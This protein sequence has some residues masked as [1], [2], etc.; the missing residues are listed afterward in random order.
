MGKILTDLTNTGSNRSSLQ[1]DD[2]LKYVPGLKPVNADGGLANKSVYP[3]NNSGA[4]GPLKFDNYVLSGNIRPLELD[5]NHLEKMGFDL[6]TKFLEYSASIPHV[7]NLHY[8]NN[9]TSV[10]LNVN[11]FKL[12]NLGKTFDFYPAFITD[13]LGENPDAGGGIGAINLDSELRASDKKPYTNYQKNFTL[14]PVLFKQSDYNGFQGH[15]DLIFWFTVTNKLKEILSDVN[16]SLPIVYVNRYESDY[17]KMHPMAVTIPPYDPGT[18]VNFLGHDLDA[19][20][21][22]QA[23]INGQQ[24][25]LHRNTNSNKI[26]P[27][28]MLGTKYLDLTKDQLRKLGFKFNGLKV[29]YDCEIPNFNKDSGMQIT[30]NGTEA[31]HERTYFAGNGTFYFSCQPG[32]MNIDINASATHKNTSF[33]KQDFYPVFISNL[34]GIQRVK[35]KFGNFEASDKWTDAYFLSAIRK[36]VP[37][38]VKQDYPGSE[39]LVFW[40]NVTPSFLALLPD[41]ISKDM[42]KEYEKL[43]NTESKTPDT[44][45]TTCKYFDVCQVPLE[46]EYGVK[47]YP[48]P[49]KDKINLEFWPPKNDGTVYTTVELTDLNGR[50]IQKNES[51][52]YGRTAEM[53][54]EGVKPGIYL[55]VYKLNTGEVITNKVMITR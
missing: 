17:R 12:M 46:Q 3:Q 43:V 24:F 39:D 27:S 50:V 42:G 28:D 6:K 21:T 54:L 30:N 23:T 18:K 48:N 9:D 15:S 2:F 4:T 38:L 31:R 53:N 34:L 13:T 47:I 45:V 37:V 26:K 8:K 49:A 20:K 14:I 19:T 32:G 55:I 35:Y 52:W 1:D 25:T 40:F 44:T 29:E 36:L 51:P 41:T 7:G 33:R 16:Q 22:I 5:R 10:E 11:D